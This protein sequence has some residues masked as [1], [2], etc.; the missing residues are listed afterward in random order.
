M[1]KW[2]CREQGHQGKPTH[3]SSTLGGVCSMWQGELNL[4][5]CISGCESAQVEGTFIS[6]TVYLWCLDILHKGYV[7]FIVVLSETCVVHCEK[8]K[9]IIF[10]VAEL[11]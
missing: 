1:P 11:Y 5:A 2:Q 8:T 4:G 6:I 10:S 3:K 9:E 7:S